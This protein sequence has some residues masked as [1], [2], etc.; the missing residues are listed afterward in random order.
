MAPNPQG[1]GRSAEGSAELKQRKKREK[2]RPPRLSRSEKK[3]VERIVGGTGRDIARA[4]AKAGVGA[5]NRAVRE[6]RRRPRREHKDTGLL[7]AIMDTPGSMLGT[8]K[9]I[10][11]PVYRYS[12]H[13]LWDDQRGTLEYLSG[14]YFLESENQEKVADLA[15]G[16]SASNLLYHG[17]TSHL[18]ESGLEIGSM[19]PVFRG[20]RAVAQALRAAK[21]RK[22]AKV[23]EEPLGPPAPQTPEQKVRESLSPARRK[24]AEQDKGYSE[25]RAKRFATAEKKAGGATGIGKLE[26]AKHELRGELPKVKFEKLREGVLTQHELDDLATTIWDHP[27]FKTGDKVHASSALLKAFEEGVTPQKSQ[28]ELLRQVF[29]EDADVIEGA[30]R[31]KKLGELTV[32][33]VNIPRSI[34]ASVDISAPM[35]QGIVG[36]MASPRV[37]YRSFAPMFKLLTSERRYQ[38]FLDALHEHPSFDQAQKAGVSFT[39]LRGPTSKFREEQF[40]SQMAETITGGKYS[41]VRASGRAYTGFLDK[42]RIDLFAELTEVARKAGV[43]VESMKEL[44]SIANFVN[45]ATGRGNLGKL[46]SSAPLL[47]AIFFAPRLIASRINLLNP[48]WYGKQSKFVR[49]EALRAMSRLA[50]SATLV[51]LMAKWAGASVELDPRSSNF[52]KIRLGNTRIDILG[53]FQQYV[54]IMS[55]LAPYVGGIKSSTTGE[56]QKFVPGF[57]KRTRWEAFE[58]FVAGKW[59]PPASFTRD[60]MK[61]TD[62]ENEPFEVQKAVVQRMIPLAIQDAKEMHEETGSWP[63]AIGAYSTAAVGIGIQTYGDRAEKKRKSEFKEWQKTAETAW[64]KANPGTP[65]P[66]AVVRA[67]RDKNEVE[68]LVQQHDDP[69]E[70]A[71]A[72]LDY[73]YKAHP[74]LKQYDSYYQPVLNGPPD[75]LQKFMRSLRRDIYGKVLENFNPIMPED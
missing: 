61:G 48:I 59:S 55:Q 45:A 13:N 37:F 46:E 29:G 60:M 52:A 25:E 17:D 41:P 50:G 71:T 9:K 3:E 47:N 1:R 70:E 5:T 23:A 40:S 20:P 24:R 11:P 72:V 65:L 2:K 43:N 18:L 64:K 31:L 62:F 49:M 42:M 35:R 32:D 26:A 39:E 22:A 57:G 63:F 10:A 68:A 73:L 44:R 4:G 12:K 56:F 7:K 33:V 74:N 66:L 30:A 28:I 16:K 8:Y 34:M 6:T 75:E 15:L 54:R 27:G 19:L 53:G 51:L 14:K 67:Q 36:G 38:G 69:R 58:G 21:A